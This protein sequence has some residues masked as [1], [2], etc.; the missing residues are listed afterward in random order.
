MRDIRSGAGAIGVMQ[1]LPETGKHIAREFN[2]PY[3]GRATL[4][5]TSSNIRLG[6]KYLQKMYKRF[7][8]NPVLATAAYNA[9]PLRVAKWL[10]DAE[11]IDAR[12]WI[13]NI[14]YN[15]TRSYV[16][17]VLTADAIFHWRLTGEIKRISSVLSAID[18]VTESV[19]GSH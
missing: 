18:P 5:D 19:A 2:Y 4:T 8:D 11:Q 1:L 13:E 10:P 3:A 7:D 16:R 9:G 17:R 6:T 15:E 12:V 14:P